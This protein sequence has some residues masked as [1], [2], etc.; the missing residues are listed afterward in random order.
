[1]SALRLLLAYLLSVAS[2]P[3]LTRVSRC[4]SPPM[5]FV[6]LAPVRVMSMTLSVWCIPPPA[7][8]ELSVP[9]HLARSFAHSDVRCEQAAR[10]RAAIPS[11]ERWTKVRDGR[12]CTS[13]RMCNRNKSCVDDRETSTVH[14]STELILVAKDVTHTNGQPLCATLTPFHSIPISF[15]TLSHLMQPAIHVVQCHIA[16]LI[17]QGRIPSAMD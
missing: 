1:M 16:A 2:A 8:A 12:G 17:R 14:P 7:T 10:P 11:V 3:H 9:Q 6:S 15:V 13:R 5:G 4:R